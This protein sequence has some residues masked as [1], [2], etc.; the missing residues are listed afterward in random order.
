M[1]AAGRVYGEFN[2]DNTVH[3]TS[4]HLG[5]LVLLLTLL[6]PPPSHQ[7]SLSKSGARREDNCRKGEEE[8]ASFDKTLFVF[9]FGN[10]TNKELVSRDRLDVIDW[11]DTA[12]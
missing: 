7:S 12:D 2:N 9:L 10:D 6:H 3:A 11:V 5:T 1:S 4:G 8:L